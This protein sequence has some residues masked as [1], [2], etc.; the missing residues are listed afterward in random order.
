MKQCSNSVVS[1]TVRQWPRYRWSGILCNCWCNWKHNLVW[2][3]FAWGCTF[4]VYLS[5][6]LSKTS[7]TTDW[8][9]KKCL[10]R[11]ISL[12]HVLCYMVQIPVALALHLHISP[13]ARVC[14]SWSENGTLPIN[15]RLHARSNNQLSLP[16]PC[17]VP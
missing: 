11:M 13:S 5:T 2:L 3:Q 17:L 8:E 10:T 7:L 12:G 1:F 14:K 15:C 16:I 4:Q 9:Y 6:Y